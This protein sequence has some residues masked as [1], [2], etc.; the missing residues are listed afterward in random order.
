MALLWQI[1]ILLAVCLLGQGLALFLPLPGSVLAM[2]LVL[3]F[4][5]LGVLKIRQMDKVTDFL[6]QNMAFFFVPACV[7]VFSYLDVIGKNFVAIVAIAILSTIFTFVTTAFT[8]RG[9]SRLV[10]KG[11]KDHG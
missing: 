10:N 7:N 4:L 5:C 8:V 3:L 1:G 9:L 6:M 11:G 2:L